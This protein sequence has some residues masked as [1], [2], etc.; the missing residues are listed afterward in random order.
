MFYDS[1]VATDSNRTDQIY[2]KVSTKLR[3]HQIKKSHLLIFLYITNILKRPPLSYIPKQHPIY[4][5]SITRLQWH[6]TWEFWRLLKLEYHMC[7]SALTERFCTWLSAPLPS[8]NKR[9]ILS[10]SPWDPIY[11]IQ[12]EKQSHHLLL[13]KRPGADVGVGYFFLHLHLVA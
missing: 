2:E 12:L 1:V 11:R 10:H 3:W 5:L 4:L 8:P 9:R 13:R 7:I 6:S